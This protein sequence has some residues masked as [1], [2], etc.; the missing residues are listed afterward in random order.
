VGQEATPI[1][2]PGKIRFGGTRYKKNFVRT[3]K[4]SKARHLKPVE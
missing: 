1:E 2:D 4:G 3:N